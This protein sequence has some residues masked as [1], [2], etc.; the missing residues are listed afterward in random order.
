M[1]IIWCMFIKEVA[2]LM[3]VVHQV[4]WHAKGDYLAVTCADGELRPYPFTF[5]VASDW[6]CDVGMH[7]Y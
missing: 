2:I 3:Q 4:A 7:P 6:S 5:T 1:H